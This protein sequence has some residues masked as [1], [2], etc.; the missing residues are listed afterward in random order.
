M[1][2]SN[3][4]LQY[5]ELLIRERHEDILALS[6][7]MNQ[8]QTAFK[9]LAEMIADQGEMI[10]DIEANV[11]SA[12]EQSKQGVRQIMVGDWS[13]FEVESEGESAIVAE[14]VLDHSDDCEHCGDYGGRTD[15]L[16]RGGEEER[17]LVWRCLLEMCIVLFFLALLR[18]RMAEENDRRLAKLYVLMD[19]GEWKE[20]CMGIVILNMDAVI[21][22]GRD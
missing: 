9:D 3:A 2:P 1:N 11:T 17:W 13:G 6:T 12:A 10:E 4:N 19:D 16:D 20:E 14:E 5:N 18:D 15:Y 21:L 8:V 7:E 22:L